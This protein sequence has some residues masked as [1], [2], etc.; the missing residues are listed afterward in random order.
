[1][2]TNEILVCFMFVGVCGMLM[3]GFPVAFSLAGVALIFAGISALFG[4]FDP[5]FLGI[6]PNRI[7]GN[8]MTS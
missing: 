7:F 1:M 5:A 8:A 3:G 6:F 4:T 2:S